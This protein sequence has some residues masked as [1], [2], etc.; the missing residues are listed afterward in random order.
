VHDSSRRLRSAAVKDQVGAYDERGTVAQGM[1]D[2]VAVPGERITPMGEA[3][4]IARREA[5]PKVEWGNSALAM[6]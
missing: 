3:V 2:E 4:K 6:A 5:A 1:S